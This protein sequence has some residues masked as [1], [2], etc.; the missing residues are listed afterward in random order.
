M[1][2]GVRVCHELEVSPGLSEPQ[3]HPERVEHERGAH[4]LSQLPAHDHPREH[5][6]HEA[7]VGNALPAAQ[8]SEIANPQAIRRRRR[9]VALDQI[10]GPDSRRIGF[11]GPPRPPPP[12]RADDPVLC[13]QPLHSATRR[14]LPDPL[15]LLPHPP[16]PVGA[17]VVLVRRANHGQQ[18]LV[19]HRARRALPGRA[20][21][22]GRRRHAQGPADRLDPET[23][24]VLIDV[25]A[26]FGRSGSSSRA[27][28]RL[29]ERRISF[30]RRNSATSLRSF[31][32]SS[33][34]PLLSP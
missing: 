30:A 15:E 28:N 25:P 11:G 17:I 3:R 20:L 34:S 29:A 5:I 1:T 21:V 24:P 13:H 33:R 8:I 31:L 6:D 27:K 2:A 26:H 32:T 22:V 7:E 14:G 9:E 23:S 16:I 19:L 12:L 4:V 10:S 18:P